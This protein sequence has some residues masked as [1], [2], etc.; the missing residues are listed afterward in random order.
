MRSARGSRDGGHDQKTGDGRVRL[1]MS[2]C[3]YT[4]GPWWWRCT[5]KG[6]VTTISTKCYSLAVYK[7]RMQGHAGNCHDTVRRCGPE[8]QHADK[9]PLTQTAF[10]AGHHTERD[11]SN[12][13]HNS[14]SCKVHGETDMQRLLS[15]NKELNRSRFVPVKGL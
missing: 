15:I 6:K 13:T 5:V 1:D 7:C 10:T 14:S 3:P 8:E 12:S 9:S 4:G 2:E 11:T